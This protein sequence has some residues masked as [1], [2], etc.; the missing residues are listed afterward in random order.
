MTEYLGS[1]YVTLNQVQQIKHILG[2]LGDFSKQNEKNF[3]LKDEIMY[4]LEGLT[5]SC[6][7][8]KSTLNLTHSTLPDILNGDITK[9]RLAI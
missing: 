5:V 3:F 1:A 4:S 2:S 6:L 8:E 7:N 9:F